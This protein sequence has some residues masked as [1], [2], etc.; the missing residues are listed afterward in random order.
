MDDKKQQ[1]ADPKKDPKRI[2]KDEAEEEDLDGIMKY[3]GGSDEEAGNKGAPDAAA[4]QA[5]PQNVQENKQPGG[6]G[7][8]E[9]EY[10][11]EEEGEFEDDEADADAELEQSPEGLGSKN[12]RMGSNIME[13]GKH[14]NKIEEGAEVPKMGKVDD[15]EENEAV[16][17]ARIEKPSAKKQAV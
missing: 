14:A 8:E 4:A 1:R 12:R 10:G 2:Q 17:S 15:P 13:K 5:K 9:S 7:E 16:R 11:S 6:A 3:E